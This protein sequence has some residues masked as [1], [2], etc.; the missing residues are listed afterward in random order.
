M[1]SYENNDKLM[2]EI[3]EACK[4]CTNM[5]EA[6]DKMTTNINYCTFIKYAKKMNIFIERKNKFTHINLEDV[7]NNK[8]SL[9]THALKLKLIKE[10]L[11][12]EKCEKCGLSEW[13]R[14]KI[15]LEL[16]HKDG[17]VKNNE[18]NN[19]EILCLNCHAQTKNYRSKRG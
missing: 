2:N 7:L 19:L 12:T 8:R 10:G 14:K 5:R 17:N 9:G 18:L 11:K 1:N 3:K 16:H 6:F 15:P 4:D 13:K